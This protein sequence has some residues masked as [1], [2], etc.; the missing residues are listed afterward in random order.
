MTPT[1]SQPTFGARRIYYNNFA[2]HL[3]NAY[4]PNMFYPGLP[5]RWSDQRWRECI[6][7][8]AA[9]GFNVFE[10]WFVPR[11]F[12]R[13]ALTADYAAEFTRQINALTEHAHSRGVKVEFLCGLAT[14][15]DQWHTYCPNDAADWAELQFLWD[16]WLERFPGVD[17]VGIFP[18]D[19]G[20]C[21]RNGCT[22]ETYID[23][24]LDISHIIKKRLPQAEVEFHTWGPP[25]FGWGNLKGPAGWKGEFIQS[26]Q[27]T[28]WDFDLARAERSMRHLLKR[29]PD[30]PAPT[31]VGI[32]MGFNSDG[33]PTGDQ[34]ARP[35][36]GE[37]ARTHPV[38]SWDFSLTEGEN[39]ILPHWRFERLFQ[40]RHE[41]RAAAPY[42]GGICFT[43]TPLLNQLTLYMAAQSFIRPDADPGAVAGEFLEGVFGP[44]GRELI[45]V[46][47]LF[48]V[49][50]DW[51]NYQD[52]R[53]SR[54]EY[55]QTM[56]QV[57]DLLHSLAGHERDTYPVFPTPAAWRQELEF[58]ASLF[59]DLSAPAPEYDALAER[60]WQHVYAIY[61]HLPEHVDPRPRAA[62]AALVRHFAN[63]DRPISAEPVLGKWA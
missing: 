57:T 13:P 29:L 41:E 2:E 46:L 16:A 14:S 58:F 54:A 36:I 12:C 22:A 7:F 48:E 39:A 11:L 49:I 40:R 50:H 3:Q 47:P 33:N 4:N 37:I 27:H 35:W 26:Y 61:D 59:A 1:P 21:S 19:P 10:F 30:F 53:L 56:R 43:M 31:S 34:D 60:Y 9:C 6:D 18:G 28:A 45:P 25:F 52:I 17:I 38:Y 5:N 63:W 23:K 42:S 8:V 15:G 24:S 51:G 44:A 55:H 62:T 32:N 20:A